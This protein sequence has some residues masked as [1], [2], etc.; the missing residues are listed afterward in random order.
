MR[1]VAQSFAL[2]AKFCGFVFCVA[3][4][5]KR[6]AKPRVPFDVKLPDGIYRRFARP[7][8]PTGSVTTLLL[9]PA[10]NS[11]PF[12]MA[13]FTDGSASEAS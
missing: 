11:R 4:K 1:S 5:N 2:F 9:N 8:P 10:I 7:T 13:S 6:G 12:A 3:P